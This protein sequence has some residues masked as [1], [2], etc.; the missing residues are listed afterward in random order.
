MPRDEAWFIPFPKDWKIPEWYYTSGRESL[1][2]LRS[3]CLEYL[4]C[5]Q[6]K[7][8]RTTLP[9]ICVSF[10]WIN[11]FCHNCKYIILGDRLTWKYFGHNPQAWRHEN[12]F[13]MNW[14]GLWRLGIRPSSMKYQVKEKLGKEI[15][16]ETRRFRSSYSMKKGYL[17]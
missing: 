11:D 13:V 17:V 6:S 5:F 8:T 10:L 4:L 1:V 15:R 2:L 14:H 12:S 16:I 9:I 7:L 3:P